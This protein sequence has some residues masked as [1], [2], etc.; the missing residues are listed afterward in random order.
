VSVDP[1]AEKVL[2]VPQEKEGAGETF[3]GKFEVEVAE[4]VDEEVLVLDAVELVDVLFVRPLFCAISRSGE[5]GK[6]VDE[7]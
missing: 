6:G 3:G 7:P 1:L 5:D 2:L 4:G